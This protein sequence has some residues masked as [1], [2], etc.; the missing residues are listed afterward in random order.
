MP[1]VS[2]TFLSTVSSSWSIS[3]SPSLDGL[4]SRRDTNVGATS[5]Q[6]PEYEVS[7]AWLQIPAR[8]FLAN[9]SRGWTLS[10]QRRTAQRIETDVNS[11]LTMEVDNEQLQE[12]VERVR[13]QFKLVRSMEP[14]VNDISTHPSAMMFDP[15]AM[16]WPP[17]PFATMTP[18]HPL[19]P[20]SITRSCASISKCGCHS[21]SRKT[22]APFP[23]KCSVLR[24]YSI[25]RS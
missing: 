10:S 14:G 22:R 16:I 5:A 18:L 11:I 1:D 3:R 6:R 7:L 15:I 13:A 23:F 19:S 21:G 8:L 17:T 12:T 25:R 24:P 20:S 9:R 2:P 4:L